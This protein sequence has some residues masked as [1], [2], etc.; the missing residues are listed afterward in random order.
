M[1]EARKKISKREMKEDKL[2]TSYYKFHDFFM[3]NQAKFLIG[4]GVVAVIVVAYI[5]Y[6][7]KIFNDNKAAA[8]LVAKVTPLMEAGS[9]KMAIDGVPAQ[10]ITGLKKIVDEYG[11][12]EEGELAKIMLANAYSITGNSEEAYKLY[13]DYS[14]SNYLLKSSALAGKAGVLETKKE[15]EDAADL[16]QEAAKIGKANP[17]NPEFLLK[18][19][20]AYLK[21][22]KKEEANALFETIKKDY[23][24]AVPYM[25]LEKYLVQAE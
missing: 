6:T 18:A 20:I 23:V 22:G 17:S 8:A 2:V 5:L 4:L 16:Y 11:S 25:E 13:N 10:N 9:Y 1:L 3:A 7:N 21:A 15:Y 12:S 14:G 24:T 19:G